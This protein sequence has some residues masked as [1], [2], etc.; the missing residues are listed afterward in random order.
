MLD[1]R[2]LRGVV[3]AAPTPLRED[4]TIDVDRLV[5]HCAWLLRQGGCDG[6]NLLGT[7]GEATS[8]SLDARIMAMRAVAAG[9]LPLDRI[10][11]GTGAAAFEDAARLTAAARDLGYAG[12]LLLPPFYYKNIDQESVLAYVQAVVARAGRE[13]LR[14]YLYHF[15]QNSGVPYAIDTVVRLH[16]LF[17]DTLIGLKD[18]SGDPA[19]A[20]ELALRIAGIDVL[21]GSEAGLAEAQ[22]LGF[23][24]C[25]SATTNVTGP[26]VQS[27]W[28][29]PERADGVRA[30]AQAAAI[31]QALARHP[32]VASVKWALADLRGE[33]GW[34]RVLP[35]L[36][37]LDGPEQR[38]L[39][40]ALA[41]TAYS[42]LKSAH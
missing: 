3:A 18:S 40:A 35:P 19:Y 36:R 42:D 26:L 14:L 17:P 7:T 25:I 21:P 13:G 39:S 2:R 24:G 29:S 33:P 41:A 37:Q 27:F 12:A 8:L 31:R 32:F 28:R 15:P 10:M 38:A 34:S 5:A 6:V 1:A 20:R 16:E 30:L 22:R 11:V 23:A 9:G 4:L